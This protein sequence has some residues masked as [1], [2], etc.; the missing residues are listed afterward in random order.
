[1]E[2]VN[3]QAYCELE[4]ST[5]YVQLV[6]DIRHFVSREIVRCFHYYFWHRYWPLCTKVAREFSLVLCSPRSSRVY[7]PRCLW[8]RCWLSFPVTTVFSPHLQ[9]LPPP[10]KVSFR[11][12]S[13]PRCLPLSRSI[14]SQ[15]P[16]I[17]PS[18][19]ISIVYFGLDPSFRYR[20]PLST[21]L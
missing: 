19:Q 2:T 14:A 20:L 3:A 6:C 7:S 1:M 8:P 11:P 17:H 21:E 16:R 4:C 5:T 18:P 15:S 9:I 10:S 12:D 13:G